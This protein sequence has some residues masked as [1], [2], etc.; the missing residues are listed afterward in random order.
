M[1]V[2][3]ALIQVSE[4]PRR[5]QLVSEPA[6]LEDLIELIGPTTKPMLDLQILASGQSI[7]SDTPHHPLIHKEK[8]SC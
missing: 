6:P 5:W 2:T 3:M 1:I 4:V 8:A 7:P